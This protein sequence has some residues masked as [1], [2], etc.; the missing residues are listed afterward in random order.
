MSV[1]SSGPNDFD[2]R[3]DLLS[4]RPKPYSI[5]RRFLLMQAGS[6]GLALLLMSTVLFWN[7]YFH[8]RLGSTL[9]QLNTTLEL[10]TQ[11]HAGHETTEHAFWE[12][13]FSREEGPIHE[14]EEHSRAFNQLLDRCM[15]F[16]FPEEDWSE[17]NELHR[18]EAKFQE[19]TTR[20]M[21]GTRNAEKDDP[22][23]RT[24]NPLSSAIE[25]KFRHVEEAQIQH[26]AALNSQRNLFS[27][28]LTLLLTVFAAL[29]VVT[30]VWFRRAHRNHLWN[31]LEELHWMRNLVANLTT[32][33]RR[34]P[35]RTERMDLRHALIRVTDLRDYQ[36]RA[37][38]ISLHVDDPADPV[39]VNGNADS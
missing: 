30:S 8:H 28:G 17:V 19:L 6:A 13:Y 26:L 31:L 39:R 29:T 24:V 22:L 35:A 5:E 38:N 4:A 34:T 14:F 16:P 1:F 33:A 23:L 20:L 9:R 2:A 10:E 7:Q 3:K 11:I 12:G 21:S 32:F 18:L 36:L 15:A 27:T 25:A 37:N